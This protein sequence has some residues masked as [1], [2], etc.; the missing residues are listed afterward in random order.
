MKGTFTLEKTPFSSTKYYGGEYTCDCSQWEDEIQTETFEF[1]VAVAENHEQE[2]EEIMEITWV[3]QT[4]SNADEA[5][6]WINANFF[7][8]IA[9]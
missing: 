1:T 4:P 8:K 6:D 2:T 3:N 5:E 9:E 7:I